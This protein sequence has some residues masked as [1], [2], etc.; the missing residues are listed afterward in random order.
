MRFRDCASPARHRFRGRVARGRD[1]ARARHC[2]ART[3]ISISARFQPATV[4]RRVVDFQALRDPPGLGRFERLIERCKR[5]DVQVVH[6]QNDFL[7]GEDV[8][9][10]FADQMRP[11]VPC[12]AVG[13]FHPS[14][15]E[16]R[17]KH[18]EQVGDAVALVFEVDRWRA[19]RAGPGAA[20]GFP[21]SAA[22]RSRPCIPTRCLRRTPG[23]RL[24]A[25]P[26]LRRQTRRWPS[27]ECTSI[28]CATVSSCFF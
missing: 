5:M 13:H 20:S 11:V 2:R 19:D 16:Q 28:A 4:L 12:S 8:V 27:A 23:D 1:Y 14:P 3:P 25:H 18:Y 9:H 6:H 24:P 26:P 21:S 7:A 17:S 22:S 10:Q 15:A